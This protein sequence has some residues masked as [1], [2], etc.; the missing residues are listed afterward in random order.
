MFSSLLALSGRTLDA[1]EHHILTADQLANGFFDIAS[2]NLSDLGVR[3]RRPPD[4][5]EPGQSTPPEISDSEWEIR[6]GRAIYILQETLPDF[7]RTGLI[8]SVDKATGS[9]RIPAST[10]I[11]SANTNLEN[12]VVNKDDE[13][14]LYSPNVRLSYTPPVE[15]PAPFPKTFHIEGLQMYLAAC[16]LTRGTMNALYSDLVFR[17]VKLVTNTPTPTRSSGSQKRRIS[18]EKSILLRSIVTGTARV[19]G[20]RGEW[21]IESIYTFSPT[22]GL[23]HKHVVNSIHPAPHQAVYDSLRMS[24]GKLLGLE[25]GVGSSSTPVNGAACNGKVQNGKGS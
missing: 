15:L 13:E 4:S 5:V 12:H 22:T 1:V 19:S 24:F 9:P 3:S 20:K 17:N 8:T 2:R 23:I 11:P 25:W 14:P 6:T 16:G 18:R 21:E 7:F 10:F